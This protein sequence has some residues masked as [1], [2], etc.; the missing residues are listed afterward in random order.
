MLLLLAK[1]LEILEKMFL[2]L[3]PASLTS[4]SNVVKKGLF[5]SFKFSDVT[6]LEL[7]EN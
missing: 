2:K 3:L 5:L 7:Y 6:Y 1:I 4:Y